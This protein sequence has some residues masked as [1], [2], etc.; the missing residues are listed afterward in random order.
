MKGVLGT[1]PGT[2]LE[3]KGNHIKGWFISQF[4]MLPWKPARYGRVSNRVPLFAQYLGGRQRKESNHLQQLVP[5]LE[6]S[7]V[8]FLMEGG[9]A[10]NS[11]KRQAGEPILSTN[12]QRRG[13]PGLAPNVAL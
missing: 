11:T 12:P 7:P 4:I 1:N 5:N 13:G 2:T 9:S 3:F 10:L 8:L 6:K